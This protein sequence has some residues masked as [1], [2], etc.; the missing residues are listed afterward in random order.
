[1]KATKQANSEILCTL[2]TV[3]SASK[4]TTHTY[5]YA[6]SP[7]TGWG[8]RPRTKPGSVS[9]EVRRPP[10]ENRLHTQAA[11][12]RVL[13]HLNVITKHSWQF[14]CKPGGAAASV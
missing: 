14:P 11:E 10:C 6:H 3:A 8:D 5:L 4:G 12:Q 7:E 9:W 13:R 2:L 1:M